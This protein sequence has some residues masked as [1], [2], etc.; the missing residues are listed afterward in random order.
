M[1]DLSPSLSRPMRLSLYFL[2]PVRFRRWSDRVVLV[3]IWH[4]SRPKENK[5][6]KIL[7]KGEN[8]LR[9]WE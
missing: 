9:K 8:I 5:K 7:E 6:S 4:L 2:S 1:S 3:G